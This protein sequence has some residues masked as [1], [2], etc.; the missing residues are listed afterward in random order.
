VENLG[1]ALDLLKHSLFTITALE[2][3]SMEGINS[4]ISMWYSLMSVCSQELK[5]GASIWNQ[6]CRA[7]LSDKLISSGKHL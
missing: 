4:Y 1:A 7:N 2:M 5:N 6:S 3:T